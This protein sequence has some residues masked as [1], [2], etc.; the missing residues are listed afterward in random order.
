MARFGRVEVRGV[1]SKPGVMKQILLDEAALMAGELADFG[2]ERMREY[3]KQ[4]GTAFSAAAA[5]A[6]VNRGPGRIRTGNM[7]NSVASRVESGGSKTLAA[8]GWLTNF[9]EYFQYQET[10]FRNRFIAM[11]TPGGRL[12][13]QGSKPIVRRNPFGGY[14][15]T[16]GMFALRDSRADVEN[17]VPKAAQKYRSRI[18]RK[19]NSL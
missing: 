12:L 1:L 18:T 6:G 11:Y 5:S 2:A 16:P 15:N 8:F 7:Y 13:T 9:E 17:Q 3:I 4:R 10:G 19:M 14:K